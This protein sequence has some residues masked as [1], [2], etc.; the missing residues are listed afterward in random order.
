MNRLTESFAALKKMVEKNEVQAEK[1]YT[2]LLKNMEEIQ[3]K[4]EGMQTSSDGNKKKF[5]R[6][7]RILLTLLRLWSQSSRLTIPNLRLAKRLVKQGE[8]VSNFIMCCSN[9]TKAK[10]LS[11]LLN[12]G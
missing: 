6:L 10:K 9:P 11:N 12:L 5:T 8:V 3:K 2:D 4:M 1:K 7:C